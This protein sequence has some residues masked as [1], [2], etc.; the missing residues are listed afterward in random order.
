MLSFFRNFFKSKIGAAIALAALVLIA[1]AFASGDIAGLRNSSG[2]SDGNAVATVGSEDVDAQQLTQGATRA[3][4]RVKQQ[5]PTATM[6]L[7]VAQGGVEQ[8]LSDLIDRTAFFVF[9][10]D[11]KILASDRLIDSEITQIPAFQGVDGKFDQNTFRQALAQQGISEKAL[12]EDIAHNLTAQVL[13]SP[14]TTGTVMPDYAARQY[15]ALLTETRTGAVAALPS[16]AFAPEK[17]PTD[18]QLAAFYK[19]HTDAFIR[20]ERRVIRYASFDKTSVK[21][22]AVPTDAEIAARY[23]ANKA[24]YAAQDRRKITQL[25]VPTE[26]AAKAVVAEVEG[27]KPLEAAAGEKGLTAA[28]LAY[29]SKEDLSSQFSP[30]VSASVFAAPVGK[31]ATPQKSALGWHV[32]RVDEEEKKPARTLADVKAELTQQ[33]V[34]EK[35]RKGFTDMAAN[36][37]D[38]ID[39]GASLPEVAK[40]FGLEIKTTA[41]LTADGQIYM[42]PGEIV[43]GDLKP[44]LPTAFTMDQEEP[45][46][47]PAV[48]G[49]TFVVFDVTDIMQSAPAP[50]AEIKNDVKEAWKIDTGSKAARAAAVKMQGEIRKGKTIEQALAAAGKPLP[51]VQDVS[52]SRPTLA[53]ALQSG[54][55]VPPPVSLLFHMA[56]GTVKV[57]SA[58]QDRVWFVVQLKTIEP[59]KVD[60]DEMIRGA[61]R[62]LGQQLGQ[63]YGDA[64]AKAIRKDVGVTEHPNAIKAVRDQLAGTVPAN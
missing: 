27:G 55:Q 9:G 51:P 31:L 44:V 14:A 36:I 12:R 7:L 42:K 58:M 28:N 6:K 38:Q 37:E 13:M 26:A 1:I 52:M 5:Q 8:V 17:D 32:I 10:K 11:H 50:L 49:Q 33:I 45:Q 16:L 64:L 56:T 35:T 30:E 3:L 20:P 43:P 18:Q 24:I 34:E 62:E 4:E 19:D 60:S 21:A 48:P 53:A 41:P 61:R 54:K 29:F 57:Q 46:V 39:N 59:G 23:D 15:A 2:L 25:I 40:A 22:P 63:A 47:A